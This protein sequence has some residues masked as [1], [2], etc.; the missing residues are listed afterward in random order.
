MKSRV[1]INAD[2]EWRNMLLG[3]TRTKLAQSVGQHN[4]KVV[5]TDRSNCMLT[6][7]VSSMK[8]TQLLQQV[9]GVGD[10]RAG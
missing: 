1:Q 5:Y 4:E 6:H 2:E 3:H 8:C 7:R 10:V 9:D